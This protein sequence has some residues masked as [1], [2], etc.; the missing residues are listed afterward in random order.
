[1]FSC[2]AQSDDCGPTC[3]VFI[4]TLLFQWRTEG[5]PQ[6]QQRKGCGLD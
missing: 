6:G 4:V 1:M 5:N 3:E 2:K